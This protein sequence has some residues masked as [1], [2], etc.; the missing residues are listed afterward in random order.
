MMINKRVFIK[1]LPDNPKKWSIFSVCVL[2][3]TVFWLF[4]TFSQTFEYTLN[5]NLAYQGKPSNKVLMN[6][7]VSQVKVRVKGQGF[8]L[9]NYTLLD[10]K[11]VINIDVSQFSVQQKGSMSVYSMNLEKEG[12]DLFGDKN[13]ALKAVAYSVDTLKLIFD[14]LVTKKLRVETKLNSSLDLSSYVLENE[15]IIPDSVEVK[16]SKFVLGTT[17]RIFTQVTQISPSISKNSFKLPLEEME[18]VWSLEF[19]SV[20]YELD[21]S[22]YEKRKFSV[23]VKCLNCPDSLRIK[24]FPS[25]ADVA[26]MAT[27]KQFAKITPDDFSLL[28]DFHDIL[29]TTEKLLIKLAEF[30]Q[31]I[32][33]L[34]LSP[35]KAEFLVSPD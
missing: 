33:E 2:T 16:G 12:N 3:A 32:K 21:I 14:E 20:V 7:P 30:P 1:L 6:S 11:K 15:R 10:K 24:L 31:G 17:S 29:P 26:F 25:Y 28:V 34:A 23:P 22:A 4:L 9:F 27:P 19:D 8:E 5:F 18:G 35:A 13:T